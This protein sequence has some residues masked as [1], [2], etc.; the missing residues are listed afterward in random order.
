MIHAYFSVDPE[1]VYGIIEKD[2]TKVGSTAEQNALKMHATIMTTK[3]P[4]IYWIPATLEIMHSIMLW[5][6]DGLESYFTMDAG[7]NV[8]VLCLEKDE[9]ELTKRLLSLEGV[10]KIISCRPGD[11]ALLSDKHLF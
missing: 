10:V 2:F 6:E 5:R 8:K 1:V 3:P 4:I 11:G 9:K 7:P